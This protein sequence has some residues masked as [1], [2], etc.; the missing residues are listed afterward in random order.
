[1]MAWITPDRTTLVSRVLGYLVTRTGEIAAL[2][3][4]SAQRALAEAFSAAQLDI[5]GNMRVEVN[6]L[7]VQTAE[8]E[9]LE[10]HGEYQGVAK[11]LAD[12][13]TGAVTVTGTGGATQPLGAT[14]IR[15][16]G[17]EYL[18]TAL[19]TVGSTVAI[20]CTTE[21]V[22]GNC[23]A[24]TV[25]TWASPAAGIDPTALVAA[26]IETGR[27]EE[28][29][30]DYRDRLLE[31]RSYPP[32]GGSLND[33]VKWARACPTVAVARAWAFAWTDLPVGYV[34]VYFTVDDGDGTESVPD[35][36]D[37]SAMDAY[38]QPLATGGTALT[39]KAPATDSLD[40]AIT[41][42]VLTGYALADVKA[43]IEAS[44][45]AF[46][47]TIEM[48]AG[49]YTIRNSQIRDALNVPGVDYYVLTSLN[50]GSPTADVTIGGYTVATVGT[51][52][53]S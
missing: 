2:I 33:Y 16:D 17:I 47:M 35:A 53:W 21:G 24:G 5:Y 30:D 27:D 50:G 52:A 28:T 51:I 29:D 31:D 34:D 3:F 42:H 1:M 37:L 20:E 40:P 45:A 10:K 19:G 46:L 4:R 48:S 23:D 13:A 9:Y 38:M 49:S 41:L 25:L 14:L 36:G 7:F 8:G 44:L 11:L 6:Q 39:I 26:D 18:T 43:A 22:D 32:Q 15:E 12:A